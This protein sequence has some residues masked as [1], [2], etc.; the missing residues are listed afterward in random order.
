MARP[1]PWTAASRRVCQ[2]SPA[3]WP[4]EWVACFE[5]GQMGQC[6]KQ[7]LHTHASRPRAGY[8]SGMAG[9]RPRSLRFSYYDRLSA[10]EK[11]TYRRSDGIAAVSLPHAAS[12]A[13]TVEQLRIELLAGK[14]ARIEQVARELCLG[15]TLRLGVPPLLVKVRSVRPSELGGELHGLYT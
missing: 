13:G 10:S 2:S 1:G 9:Q 15:I 7:A 8:N 14:R 6:S 4:S 3:K 5:S 12:L 11:R